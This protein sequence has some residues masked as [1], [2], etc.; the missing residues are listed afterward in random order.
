MRQVATELN[1]CMSWGDNESVHLCQGRQRMA[2]GPQMTREE[3][4]MGLTLP[5]ARWF[6][7]A[8]NHLISATRRVRPSAPRPE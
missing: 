2:S 3:M 5:V 1:F 7:V 6:G 4:P 8:N